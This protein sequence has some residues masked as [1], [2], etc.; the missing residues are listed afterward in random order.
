MTELHK[1][2][3]CF[4]NVVKHTEKK[5]TLP[6]YTYGTVSPTQLFMT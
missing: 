3:Y 5:E 4:F 1:I 2:V 6:E